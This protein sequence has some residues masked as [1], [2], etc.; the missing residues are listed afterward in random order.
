MPK[1]VERRTCDR[2]DAK[3]VKLRPLLLQ[4]DPPGSVQQS[5]LDQRGG[6]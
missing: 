5:G 2:T 6:I 1:A 4:A 3:A